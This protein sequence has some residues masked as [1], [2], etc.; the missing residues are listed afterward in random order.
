MTDAIDTGPPVE[1]EVQAAI[2]AMESGKTPGIDSLQTELLK[3]DI[4]TATKVLTDL[5]RKIWEQ[6]VIPQNWSKGLIVKLPK[7]ENLSECDNW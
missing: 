5:F 3:T 6:D 4:D 2:K 7:K 1:A